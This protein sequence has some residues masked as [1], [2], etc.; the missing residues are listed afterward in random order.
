LE[1]NLK[2]AEFI[3]LEELAASMC[4]IIVSISS[5]AALP[6]FFHFCFSS[7]FYIIIQILN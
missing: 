1:R 3:D 4:L 6:I 7:L 2:T 5:I